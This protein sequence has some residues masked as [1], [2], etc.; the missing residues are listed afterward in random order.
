MPLLPTGRD[1]RWLAVGNLV[2]MT[3]TGATLSA[4]VVFLAD[5]KDLPL[6]QAAGLLT[7]AGL[8]GV[9]GAV[10]LGQLSDRYGARAV[11][12]AGE[13]VGAVTTLLLLVAGGA[14]SCALCLAVRQ[15]AVSGTT[16]A[17]A[18]L[19]GRLVPAPER[20]ALRAYQRSVSN[21]GFS[22][23][24]LGAAAAMTWGGTALYVLIAV[25]AATYL[26]GAYATTRLPEVGRG[27]RRAGLAKDALRDAGYLGASL[28][29]AV[30]TLNR[31]VVSLGVPLWIVYATTLPHWTVSAAMIANTLLV[32][33]L[34]IPLSPYAQDI[35]RSRRSLLAAGLLTAAGCAALGTA[36]AYDTVARLVW[37]LF[38]LACLA[39]ALGEI[40]GAAAGWTLSYE[41]APEPL[42][43]QYQGVWQLIADGSSKAAGPAVIGWALAAGPAGWTAL[44]AVFAATG[45]V[46]PPLIRWA[47][48]RHTARTAGA[49]ELIA[50]T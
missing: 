27:V 29:N 46:S 49:G 16:A 19:M 39:L 1:Q 36:D 30:H 37:P 33:L 3:G 45:A 32:I 24:A 40:L 18:T 38:A 5:A 42:L 43:G 17:R 2:N 15:L 8:I 12:L 35:A 6:G 25:D 9:T 10:P 48:R 34:Q 11:A 41:L 44:A 20:A 21:I 47:G 50:D 22:L 23:G 26:F 7:A 14:W 31:A 4:L 28:L 13:L